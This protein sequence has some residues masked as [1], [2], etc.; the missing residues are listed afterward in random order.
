MQLVYF[1]F[2]S[3]SNKSELL[4]SSDL[5]ELQK[6]IDS[7]KE[8]H[9]TNE[10]FTITPFNPNYISDFKGEQLGMSLEEINRLHAYRK[11]N[12]FIN[13]AKE[14]QQVTQV[15][16]SLLNKISAYFKFPDWVI[17]QNKKIKSAVKSNNDLK[18]IEKS[19]KTIP[20]STNDINKATQ[21][22]LQTVN[23]IGDKL[24]ARIVNYRAR[25]QGFS[26]DYQL[27]EVWN[28]DS[29]VV[30]KVLNTFKIITKP[31]IKRI[32]IN[33]AT[34]KE[35]LKTPY[36]DYT[37]CKKIFEYR[38]QVAELQD[39]SELKNIKGFP[40]NKY[41]RIIIYLTAE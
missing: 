24:S 39:I 11:Q 28:I 31:K 5:V 7:L 23:G 21:Q 26:Y 16:D 2:S 37:L 20:V 32:N 25:L 6:Q 8:I 40:L 22:D 3:T 18:K 12:K 38:D 29:V 36:I 35:V 30:K 14:F 33:T 34:F 13:S 9:I 41:E 15:S 4:P 17:A 10:S 19:D 1:Y 27:Y